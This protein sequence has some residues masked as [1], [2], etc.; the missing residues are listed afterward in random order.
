MFQVPIGEELLGLAVLILGIVLVFAFMYANWSRTSRTLKSVLT[1]PSSEPPDGLSPT[2]LGWVYAR[3]HNRSYRDKGFIAALVSLGLRG[4]L[5]IDDRDGGITFRRRKTEGA[6]TDGE[7]PAIE[8]AIMTEILGH[9]P[10]ASTEF[11]RS[12]GFRRATRAVRELIMRWIPNRYFAV[13]WT[14]IVQGFVI[15]LMSLIMFYSAFSG[16]KTA[17]FGAAFIVIF[18]VAIGLSL[19]GRFAVFAGWA[20]P[21]KAQL[22]KFYLLYL[23]VIVLFAMEIDKIY[24]LSGYDNI[25]IFFATIVTSL[26]MGIVV[27]VFAIVMVKPKQEGKKLLGQIEGFRAYLSGS[28]GND[29]K[30]IDVSEVTVDLFERFLPYAIAL[31]VEQAWAE[32]F[33]RNLKAISYREHSSYALNFYSGPLFR[34]DAV[35][36]SITDIVSKTET[37]YRRAKLFG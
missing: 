23:L 15:S 16:E 6:P 25:S 4:K 21:I 9:H 31:G 3:A 2:A 27:G 34:P 17:A 10:N 33:E 13:S 24:E 11:L 36:G 30:L 26:I 5:V 20:S 14:S 22:W 18:G 28:D 35:A 29:T 19:A 8:R 32:R 12:E 37:A 7:L 1:I